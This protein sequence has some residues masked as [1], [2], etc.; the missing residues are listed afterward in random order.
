MPGGKE[1]SHWRRWCWRRRRG[2][3]GRGGEEENQEEEEEE[4][5]KEEEEENANTPTIVS[6]QHKVH[7][8][9]SRLVVDISLLGLGPEHSIERERALL[10]WPALGAG[11]LHVHLPAELVHLHDRASTVLHLLRGQRPAA[12]SHSHFVRLSSRGHGRQGCL[13]AA[14]ATVPYSK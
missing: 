7:Y 8:R 6:F 12:D 3:E 11:R 1:G 14:L 2:E 9:S 5:E 4:E 13:F 10:P